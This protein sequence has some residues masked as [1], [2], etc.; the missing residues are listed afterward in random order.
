MVCDGDTAL[1]KCGL[2]YKTL[3]RVR[4]FGTRLSA[5]DELEVPDKDFGFE[6]V[7]LRT[8]DVDF[9]EDESEDLE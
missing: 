4:G 1:M 2:C 3:S 9:D 7:N 6:N 5:A 8:D